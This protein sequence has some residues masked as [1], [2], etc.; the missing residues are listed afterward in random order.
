MSSYYKKTKNDDRI[1]DNADNWK[2]RNQ[3]EYEQP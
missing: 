1:N 3:G 2:T